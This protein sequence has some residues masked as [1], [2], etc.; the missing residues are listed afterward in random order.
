MASYKA[1]YSHKCRTTLKVKVIRDSLKVVSNHQQFYVDLKRKE[2]EFQING[3]VFLKVSLWK[4][5]F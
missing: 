2:I 1:L 5:I 4:K 3:K